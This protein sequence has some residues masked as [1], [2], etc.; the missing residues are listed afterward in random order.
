ML[1]IISQSRLILWRLQ[2]R[3]KTHLQIID[4][5]KNIE[6][7]L[8]QKHWWW[9]GGTPCFFF[10]FERFSCSH[11]KSVVIFKI[12]SFVRR[13][14]FYQS[15]DNDA[16]LRS[17]MFAYRFGSED[18]LVPLIRQVYLSRQLVQFPCPT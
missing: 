17:I 11:Q 16:S 5:R 6:K 2:A 7:S 13:S 3:V 10:F 4:Q 8:F 18:R 14:T 1:W 9:Y 12:C 15:H